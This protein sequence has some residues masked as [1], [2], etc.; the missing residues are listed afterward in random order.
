VVA[1]TLEASGRVFF[2]LAEARFFPLVFF[3]GDEVRLG[4][5]RRALELRDACER[6]EGTVFMRGRKTFVFGLQAQAQTHSKEN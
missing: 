6:R 2:F 1:A 5:T 4:L 3:A